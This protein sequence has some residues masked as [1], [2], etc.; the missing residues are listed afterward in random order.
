MRSKPAKR[1]ISFL[2]AVMA[3]IISAPSAIAFDGNDYEQGS[4]GVLVIEFNR[5]Y[6]RDIE[7]LLPGFE[8]ADVDYR[9]MYR[10]YWIV[11]F[12]DKRAEVVW[13]AIDILEEDPAV[14]HAYP[15]ECLLDEDIGLETEASASSQATGEAVKGDAN[16]D[17]DLTIADATCIQKY[18]AKL[19]SSEQIHLSSANVSGTGTVSVRDATIIQKKL[20]GLVTDW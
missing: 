20:V 17:G 5:G 12:A 9:Y 4:D 8:I 19:L 7:E 1:I 14:L 18:L 16:G 15:D 3:L 11:T 2:L 10:P 6:N 13:A